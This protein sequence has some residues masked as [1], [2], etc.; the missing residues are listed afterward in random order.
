[1]T[2]TFCKTKRRSIMQSIRRQNTAPEL[3]L[4]GLLRAGGFRFIQHARNLRGQPDLY[5]PGRRIAIFVHGCFWHGHR[6]C[7]K[8]LNTPKSNAQYW[9]DKI[10]RNRRRDN[11]VAKELRAQGLAVYTIWE[12]EI[13]RN[14]IPARLVSSLRSRPVS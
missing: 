11:R 9:V 10:L 6:Y 12:C 1:M 2:D 4:A 7:A 8:G 5:F 13:R 3:R 14:A